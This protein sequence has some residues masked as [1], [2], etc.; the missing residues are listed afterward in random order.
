MNGD[1]DNKSWNFFACRW[2][3]YKYMSIEKSYYWGISTEQAT[4]ERKHNSAS[5]LTFCLH[6][7]AFSKI[8]LLSPAVYRKHSINNALFISKWGP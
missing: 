3:I 6:L 2:T 1:A 4:I 5:V 7:H 8:K